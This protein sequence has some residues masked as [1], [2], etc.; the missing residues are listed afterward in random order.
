MQTRRTLPRRAK[1][2][3]VNCRLAFIVMNSSSRLPC[4]TC[5]C[6]RAVAGMIEAPARQ[7]NSAICTGPQM[8]RSAENIIN[9]IQASGSLVLLFFRTNCSKLTSLQLA[10]LYVDA[11]LPASTVQLTS[12]TQNGGRL[13]FLNIF[14]LHPLSDHSSCLA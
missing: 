6:Q 11:K 2:D 10:D 9:H 14:H 7:L 13:T 12:G 4:F 1:C 3:R 5:A 8:T